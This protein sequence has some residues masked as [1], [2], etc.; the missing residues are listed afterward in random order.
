MF[1][2]TTDNNRFISFFFVFVFNKTNILPS[3]AS[4]PFPGCT[5]KY[6]NPDYDGVE[7][8]N[9]DAWNGN[10]IGNESYCE[11][12]VAAKYIMITQT[13]TELCTGVI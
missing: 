5:D 10:A 13:G 7:V 1:E 8:I 12:N 2:P 11:R 6:E 4:S 9:R 3:A